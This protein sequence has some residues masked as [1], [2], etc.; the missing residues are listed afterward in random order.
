MA[1]ISSLGVGS[2]IDIQG[3]VSG[4]LEAEGAAKSARL[5]R[6]EAEYQAKLSLYSSVKSA[7]SD[8][9]STFS[10]LR[11]TSSYNSYIGTSSDSDV[12]TA[13]VSNGAE[14][15]NYDVEVNQL[16]QSQKLISSA[17][18]DKNSTNVGTGTLV[19][20]FGTY[21]YDGV[22]AVTGFTPDADATSKEI[23]ITDGTLEGIRDSINDADVGVRA[24]IIND[25]SVG[26]KL[27]MTSETGEQNA[28]NV[29]V[30]AGTDS[31]GTD[32]D[33]SGLSQLAYDP[34]AQYSGA[35][36]TNQTE[37]Q[38]AL[39][40]NATIDGIAITSESNTISEVIDRVTLELK[41]T[42]T[43]TEKLTIGR[44]TTNIKDAV[45]SFVTGYNDLMTTL[46][47]SS[48]YDEET[49]NSGILIGDATV[50]GIV[51]QIRSVLNTTTAD[52]LAEFNSFSSI[53]ILTTR[54]GTLEFDTS[55]LDEALAS[56]PDEV[57]DL[58]AGGN[59][60]SFSSQFTIDS[61]TDNIG[62]GSYSVSV[63]GSR[64][65]YTG[66]SYF[67]AS[68]S[69]DFSAGVDLELSVDGTNSGLINFSTDYY[70]GGAKTAA[71]ALADFKSDLLSKINADATLSAAGASITVDIEEHA[72]DGT[73]RIALLSDK[74]GSGSSVS[75]LQNLLQVGLTNAG[76]SV[77]GAG[78][79][80]MQIGGET[81]TFSNG[82]L[83]GSGVYAGFVLN[84]ENSFV[85]NLNTTIQVSKGTISALDTM[86]NSFLDTDGL[87]D[88]RSDG[89][90]A[91]ITT[92][93]EQ[94]AAL[95][96][97]LVK[98]EQRYIKQFTA[99]DTLVAQLNSTSSYLENQLA[100]LPG[101]AKQK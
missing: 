33:N 85:G 22:G 5:D 65:V 89:I 41:S 86:V 21:T 77:A 101:A 32:E 99:M 71:Q 68:T 20:N 70:Q 81:A 95:A 16:A 19:I 42:S 78:T 53:G 72:T 12:F 51:N 2:G 80:D 35:A 87:L 56:K 24:S 28:L 97:R 43:S 50:R 14:V 31:D 39:S 96:E 36:L 84:M 76:T 94:R 29:T 48:F 6:K 90:N 49:G 3:L 74:F 64:G 30:K 23:E 27:I 75:I 93:G 60:T 61:V 88:A 10:D 52:P 40:A 8:F 15:T 100:S 17:F 58:L 25:P 66:A 59:A 67:D 13:S 44:D 55:K 9:K 62:G 57:K 26:Y 11:F 37:S 18:A 54:D 98:V 91:S 34:T 1:S 47:S 45:Q 92:I 79:G 73:Y 63:D 69:L 46:R 4:L 82:V 38:K 83:T 7:L